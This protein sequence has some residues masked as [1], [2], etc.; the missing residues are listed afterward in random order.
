MLRGTAQSC[1]MELIQGR[2]VMMRRL[3]AA[4]A[5]ALMTSACGTNATAEGSNGSSGQRDFA[6]G[7][8]DRVDLAGHY[9]VRV[10]VG[11][12]PSV[13]AEGE[14]AE[15]DRLEIQVV[16][17]QL[18]IGSKPGSWTSTSKTTVHVTTPGLQAAAISGSGNMEVAA[19][20]TPQFRGAVAG[21]GTLLMRGLETETAT[22]DIG[23]SGSVR[24]A[25]RTRAV[26]LEVAGSGDGQLGELQA[27]TARISIAGN[28]D[29]DVHASGTAAVSIVGSGNV[30][31]TGGARC[32]VEKVGSGD[33]R[34]G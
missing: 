34:C 1:I 14:Q 9:D 17:G 33:V 21:S 31:V 20:R 26:N 11:G 22:F 16:D 28:G 13:R 19:L 18:R 2:A 5:I 3:W 15:L 6:V 7:A 23:G 4:A 25:G 24:A 10:T 8:F 29:A 12:A 30:N 32:T 27:E